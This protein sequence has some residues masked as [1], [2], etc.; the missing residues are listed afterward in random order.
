MRSSPVASRT[1]ATWGLSR[2][3]GYKLTLSAWFPETTL[4]ATDGGAEGGRTPDLVN[5]IHALSQL[6]YG[7]I[8][9]QAAGNC[10][11]RS[12]G[13]QAAGPSRRRAPPHQSRA[14]ATGGAR[15]NPG[16]R[17]TRHHPAS[18]RRPDLPLRRGGFRASAQVREPGAGSTASPPRMMGTRVVTCGDQ[19]TRSRSR[20]MLAFV[21]DPFPARSTSFV[22]GWNNADAP[23]PR[24]PRQVKAG[25]AAA[26]PW[27]GIH[28]RSGSACI[29]H[30]ALYS[31]S[32][33]AYPPTAGTRHLVEPSARSCAQPSI[34]SE[35]TPPRRSN[36]PQ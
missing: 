28:G 12:P 30:L 25:T 7:P 11:Q 26:A 24:S 27:V 20:C 1:R 19:K 3:V 4:F 14:S 13:V 5:A 6:S 8:R 23:L 36:S 21:Q 32:R 16:R 29:V 31:P 15:P 9:P 35:A 33:C 2:A 18:S 34:T 17:Q 22:I 10:G